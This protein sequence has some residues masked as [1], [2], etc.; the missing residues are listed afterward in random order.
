MTETQQPELKKEADAKKIETDSQEKLQRERRY[1]DLKKQIE[2]I[3]KIASLHNFDQEKLLTDDFFWLLVLGRIED[4]REKAAQILN[5]YGITISI[6]DLNKVEN[7]LQ[8]FALRFAIDDI[9]ENELD[10]L[11]EAW[12]RRTLEDRIRFLQSLEG[13]QPEQI[14]LLHFIDLDDF[15]AI[16]NIYGHQAGDELLKK[17]VTS[18]KEL[19]RSQDSVYRYGGEEFCL[20]QVIDKEN[21]QKAAQ[22][23]GLTLEEFIIKRAEELRKKIIS[24]AKIVIDEKSV[25]VTLSTGV[26][27]IAPDKHPLDILKK[28]DTQMYLAKNRG[29]DQL[30]SD[31]GNKETN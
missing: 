5:K 22:Q 26:T 1:N 25:G 6:G 21:Y 12:T 9:Q 18:L 3:K 2:T 28:G 15:S 14:F 23:E 8:E 4:K 16:N 10:P 13:I 27:L 7:A 30:S 20:L 19:T 11:T 24:R 31:I 29:K 17:I